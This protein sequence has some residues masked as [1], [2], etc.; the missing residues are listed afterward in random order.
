M[1]IVLFVSRLDVVVH[2]SNLV[3][4]V[5]WLRLNSTS[6]AGVLQG[7]ST[8]IGRHGIRP[9]KPSLRR[10]RG[11]EG[12]RQLITAFYDSMNNDPEFAGK[13]KGL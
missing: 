8:F 4:I 5:D 10:L 1:R 6:L 9:N 13:S 3:K 11:E 12:V 7:R 2:V